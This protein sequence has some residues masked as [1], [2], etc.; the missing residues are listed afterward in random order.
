M[1]TRHGLNRGRGRFYCTI[2][3]SGLPLVPASSESK[4]APDN[5]PLPQSPLQSPSVSATVAMGQDD[6]DDN[7]LESAFELPTSLSK[8]SLR[9]LS[10]HAS[11]ATLSTLSEWA[12]DATTTTTT[13]ATS[14]FFESDGHPRKATLSAS[15]STD[16]TTDEEDEGEREAKEVKGLV[17]PE[18]FLPKDLVRILDAKKKGLAD[19][20]PTTWQHPDLHSLMPRSQHAKDEDDF[21]KGLLIDNDSQLSPSCLLRRDGGLV[22]RMQSEVA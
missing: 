2:K 22:F 5:T 3:A 21:E 11:K 6:N 13:S 19:A 4:L 17:L 1:R 9:P 8:L 18:S 14:E 15:P 12:S 16:L 10:H 7:S 20:R